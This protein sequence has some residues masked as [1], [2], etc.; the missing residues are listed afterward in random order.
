MIL[1]PNSQWTTRGGRSIKFPLARG[2]LFS[3]DL[4]VSFLIFF[5]VVLLLLKHTML[6]QEN[7]YHRFYS[8]SL[9]NIHDRI[10]LHLFPDYHF[11]KSQFPSDYE[12]FRES[13]ALSREKISYDAYFVL[14]CPSE[15]FEY[16]KV[17]NDDPMIRSYEVVS[18]GQLCKLDVVVGLR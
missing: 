15:H 6:V 13:L 12:E 17:P 7:N 9:E 11:N 4:V 16:G 5:T 2:Q 18:N 1:G 10:Q 14:S 3:Q 8:N